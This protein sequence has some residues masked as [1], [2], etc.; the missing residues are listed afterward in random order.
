MPRLPQGGEELRGGVLRHGYRL[1]PAKT[2]II[3]GPS[4]G[5][6]PF[7]RP[8]VGRLSTRLTAVCLG[9]LQPIAFRSTKTHGR[10]SRNTYPVAEI[11][12]DHR[13]LQW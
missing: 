9:L 8:P 7:N 5:Y 3:L 6:Q 2:K 11:C 1:R 4:K 13:L 10:Y 12:L